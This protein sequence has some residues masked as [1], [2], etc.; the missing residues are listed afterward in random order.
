[1]VIPYPRSCSFA[2][3]NRGHLVTFAYHKYD[4]NKLEKTNSKK[5][6]SSGKSKEKDGKNHK[7]LFPKELPGSNY[8]FKQFF[9]VA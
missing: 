5:N 8:D 4:F 1:M 6:N 9:T 2:W 7:S 3:N